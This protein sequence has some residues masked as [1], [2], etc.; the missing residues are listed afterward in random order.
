MTIEPS[1]STPVPQ[2]QPPAPEPWEALNERPPAAQTGRDEIP[3]SVHDAAPMIRQ[4]PQTNRAEGD[5]AELGDGRV[6]ET[7]GV[8]DAVEHEKTR[9]GRERLRQAITVRRASGIEWVRPSELFARAGASVSGRGID[10]TT[11]LSRGPRS[12]TLAGARTVGSK[13]RNLP[14]ISAFGKRDHTAGSTTRTSAG[15]T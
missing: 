11:A 15:M 10:F 4:E 13:T 5:R 6:P 12:A 14:P 9:S 1:P 8:P 7:T 2:F 3:D